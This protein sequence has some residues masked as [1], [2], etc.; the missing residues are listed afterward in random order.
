ML[1]MIFTSIILTDCS[2]S[3]VLHCYTLVWDRSQSINVH[4][5]PECHVLVTECATLSVIYFDKV[6]E[7]G[8]LHIIHTDTSL[9][10]LYV[11]ASDAK[12]YSRS[13][14]QYIG[15]ALILSVNI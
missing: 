8:H 15:R 7:S 13:D 5:E 10:A 3:L 11:L 9:L 14:F 1:F 4:S 6:D 2:C 12:T